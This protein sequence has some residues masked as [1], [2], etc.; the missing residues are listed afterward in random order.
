LTFVFSPS[1]RE[2]LKKGDLPTDILCV[3]KLSSIASEWE[4]KPVCVNS[5]FFKKAKGCDY[6]RAN[7]TNWIATQDFTEED[8]RHPVGRRRRT[9]ILFGCSF[10]LS[11]MP[12]VVFF[13]PIPKHRA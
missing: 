5:P 4:C 9:V 10:T 8:I 1:F 11:M 6:L 2:K 12:T 13:S 3:E 7:S